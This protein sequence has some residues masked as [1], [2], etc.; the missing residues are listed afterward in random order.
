M[1]ITIKREVDW[2]RVHIGVLNRKKS[3]HCYLW[4]I[5][6][7]RGDKFV[8]PCNMTT[9]LKHQCDSLIALILLCQVTS[10]TALINQIR[11]PSTDLHYPAK[12]FWHLAK[13]SNIKEQYIIQYSIYSC[14]RHEIDFCIWLSYFGFKSQWITGSGLH[15][16]R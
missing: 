15:S 7:V 10:L 14:T 1:W 12:Y 8:A 5:D 9:Y 4:K 13:I 3:I 11:Q 6:C 16:C 2:A